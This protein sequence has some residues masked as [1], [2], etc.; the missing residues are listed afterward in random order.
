MS[1]GVPGFFGQ[2]AAS[3]YP[4][5]ID[6]VTLTEL[7][8]GDGT[9][10]GNQ[11]FGI[12]VV[13]TDPGKPVA[14]KALK[15][16][17][18]GTFNEPILT[19]F[20]LTAA[21][22]NFNPDKT[23]YAVDSS[24]AAFDGGAGS[25]TTSNFVSVAHFA[26]R[27]D[28]VNLY[29]NHFLAVTD[30]NKLAYSLGGLVWEMH[31]AGIPGAI[32]RKVQPFYTEEGVD[33]DPIF[34][35]CGE[36]SGGGYFLATCYNKTSF[37]LDQ[38]LGSEV[39]SLARGGDRPSQRGTGVYACT[40][41]NVYQ[42]QDPDFDW[43]AVNAGGGP[44][45]YADGFF[46]IGG[47]VLYGSGGAF[48]N[49]GLVPQPT[50]T[51]AFDDR[52]D[53]PSAFTQGSFRFYGEGGIVNADAN[54][55]TVQQQT[56]ASQYS[57]L[58]GKQVYGSPGI[59]SVTGGVTPIGDGNAPLT[60]AR[61][62]VGS[63][64]GYN[65]ENKLRSYQYNNTVSVVVGNGGQIIF[66]VKQTTTVR[67]K[68]DLNLSLIDKYDTLTQVYDNTEFPASTWIV[69]DKYTTGGDYWMELIATG[70]PYYW[71]SGLFE[72]YAAQGRTRFRGGSTPVGPTRRY[73]GMTN[74]AGAYNNVESLVSTDPGFT[75]QQTTSDTIPDIRFPIFVTDDSGFNN[76]LEDYVQPGATFT[77]ELQAS[78]LSGSDTD[79]DTV[80]PS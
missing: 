9:L 36:L 45:Q 57:S 20:L 44:Y 70:D 12:D 67:F 33:G 77:V 49:F 37:V 4:P 43:V 52:H 35:A 18:D 42:R 75:D 14:G 68:S 76:R 41:T 39:V 47:G 54:N 7:S 58:Y 65:D 16:Y 38:T 59:A 66:A 3:G 80:T 13:M 5:I 15:G 17:I 22:N 10:F 28:R 61:D 60:Y 40:A 8:P 19:D 46:T 11:A 21:R 69:L 71:A 78:N 27:L 53:R 23:F 32:F 1:T 72:Y 2:K 55:L 79:S 26:Q 56:T 31:D 63:I 74:Y 51:G 30:D 50:L 34:V 24:G 62:I 25:P 64:P 73:L 6:S 48:D 29:D